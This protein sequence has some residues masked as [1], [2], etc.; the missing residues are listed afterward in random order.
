MTLVSLKTLIFFIIVL[1]IY[2]IVARNRQWLVLLVA[3]LSFFVLSVPAYTIIYML[4]SAVT[5]YFA[6]KYIEREPAGKKAVYCSTVLLNAGI[7]VVL[8][9]LNFLLGNV[10]SFLGILGFDVNIPVIRLVASLGVSFYTLQIIGYLTNVYWGLCKCQHNFAKLL[11]FTCY[12]PQMI[13]GPISRYEQIEE[14]LFSGHTFESDRVCRG[15]F[16]ILVGVFKKMVISEQL[17]G[18]TEA[19]LV[20]DSEYTGL[21]LIFGMAIYVLRIYADFAGCM[22]IVL[23]ASE[24]MGIRLPENFKN[25]FSAKSIQEFWQRWHITLGTWLKDYIMYPILRSKSFGKLTKFL[26]KKCGKQASK[27]IPTYLAML[28]LWLCMGI[29]HGGGW[30]FIAEG[31]WFWIV[32]VLG[33]IFK[34]QLEKVSDV[35]HI[36]RE[37]KWWQWWQQL[38][39]AVIFAI[40]ILFFRSET[41][42]EAFFI[43]K[44]ALDVNQIILSVNQLPTVMSE[45]DNVAGT[46]KILWTAASV[47]IGIVGMYIF[48]C[49]EKKEM[50]V[51]EC[52][53]SKNI[54]YK[55]ATV[56]I[57]LFIIIIFGAY[58]PGYASSEFIYGGF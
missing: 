28:V 8:K 52:W 31:L 1:G 19:I 37:S 39:T 25:P 4:I 45:L 29:W 9:Y 13:S 5:V 36:N 23:G 14:D 46:M 53:Y 18:V 58:G 34:K 12:F 10:G 40:G 47:G 33:Q 16:R 54:F 44:N 15:F 55:Y 32:I 56:Y 20:N 30:N 26:K 41:V 2:Y 35:L 3:S 6:A 51:S 43:L 22:D 38:R 7:L 21:F 11:L 50:S 49:I 42:G 27:Q 24:C 57:L 48:S 17:V